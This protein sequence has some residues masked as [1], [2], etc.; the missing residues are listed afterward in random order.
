MGNDLTMFKPNIRGVA[1]NALG[2]GF[3]GWRNSE[4]DSLIKHRYPW[5]RN[6]V[7]LL[8]GDDSLKPLLA[9]SGNIY[10]SKQANLPEK[11]KS[12]ALPKKRIAIFGSAVFTAVILLISLFNFQSDSDERAELGTEVKQESSPADCESLLRNPDMEFEE[13]LLGTTHKRLNITET[14]RAVLGGVQFRRVSVICDQLRADFGLTI[15]LINGVWQ[16]KK[17]TRLEN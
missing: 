3:A 6:W 9:R 4:D 1:K 14:Q 8:N 2:F 17:F 16:L 5:R 10:L 7:E 15:I 12:N 13:W 11:G